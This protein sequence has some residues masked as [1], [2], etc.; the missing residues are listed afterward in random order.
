MPIP[1]D[2]VRRPGKEA[3]EERPF[4]P[5]F[6]S[7]GTVHL[8]D[9]MADVESKCDRPTMLRATESLKEALVRAMSRGHRVHIDGIGTFTPHLESRPVAAPN[10]IRSP[11]VEVTSVNFVPDATLVRQLQAADIVRA[12]Q[13]YRNSPTLTDAELAAILDTHFATHRELRTPQF[14]QLTGLRP[15]RA[16][17]VLADLVR[18]HLLLREGSGPTTHY[19]RP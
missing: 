15:D 4:F 13:G 11:S 12:E 2:L 18:R 9:L 17:A 19:L 5:R 10:E 16:R 7:Q 14:T 8:D 1:Y 6:V 3:L